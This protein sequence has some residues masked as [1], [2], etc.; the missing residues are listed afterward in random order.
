MINVPLYPVMPLSAEDVRTLSRAHVLAY[1]RYRALGHQQS[2]RSGRDL[3]P[4][5]INKSLWVLYSGLRYNRQLID[6][7]RDQI[8]PADATLVESFV[9]RFGYPPDP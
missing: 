7:Y 5:R 1:Q 9:D 6:Q 8:A 4:I 2:T 3:G